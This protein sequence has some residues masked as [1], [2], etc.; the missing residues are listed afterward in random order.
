MS[1]GRIYGAMA[2]EEEKDVR[3]KPAGE[4]EVEQKPCADPP[5]PGKTIH[6][7]R[8]IPLVPEKREEEEK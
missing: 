3:L 4:V 2:E 6:R 5:P 8:P 1:I 7:R